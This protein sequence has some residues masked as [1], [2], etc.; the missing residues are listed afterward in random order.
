VNAVVHVHPSTVVLMTICNKPL[1]PLYGAY[2]PQSLRL[3]L[4][5]IPTFKRSILIDRPEL[6][7]ELAA[8]MGQSQVCLMYGH[9]V[10]T[11]ANSVEEATLLAIHLND[12]AVMNYQANLLGDVSTIPTEEQELFRA[13]EIDA[14]YGRPR[15]GVPSGR[16]ANLWRYYTRLAEDLAR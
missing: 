7:Q 5:G 6:G 3:V 2:D 12:I 8:A 14:G 9:G 13:M 1:L 10:T 15:A 4:A 16:A 11:A